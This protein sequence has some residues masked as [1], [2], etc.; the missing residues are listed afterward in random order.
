MVR[1]VVV[2]HASAGVAL[3]HPIP[4]RSLETL[5][6]RRESLKD[7]G[8]HG[9]G[10]SAHAAIL[11]RLAANQRAAQALG[12]TSCAIERAGAGR[13]TAWGVPPGKWR[14]YMIPDWTSE[15]K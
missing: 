14:R 12:W 13:F 5:Y 9:L 4:L 11:D 2:K 1:T 6:L 8:A 10:W 7:G 3:E 15:P